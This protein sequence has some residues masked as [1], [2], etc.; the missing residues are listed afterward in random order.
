MTRGED[1]RYALKNAFDTTTYRHTSG[2]FG[3]VHLLFDQATRSFDTKSYEA[4]CL[5][6]RTTVGAACYLY[7]TREKVWVGK[8]VSGTLGKPLRDEHGII[9]KVSFTE[10]QQKTKNRKVLSLYQLSSLD[11]IIKHGDLI[12][13]LAEAVDRLVWNSLKEDPD[14]NPIKAIPI[15]DEITASK[16]LEDTIAIIATLAYEAFLRLDVQ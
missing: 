5:L 7:L 2:V 9:R 8:N 13:H 10:L 11:R 1:F 12:A 6:C 15:I 3:Y 16:D 14:K 4:A